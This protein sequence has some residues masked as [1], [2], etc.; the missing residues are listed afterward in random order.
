MVAAG[1]AQGVTADP[2]GGGPSGELAE[3]DGHGDGQGSG[4]THRISIRYGECDQQGVV[5][6][7]HYLAF[8]DD[9]MDHWMRALGGEEWT[10]GW[11]VMLKSAAVT[12]EG[13]ARW[14]EVLEID[15]EVRRWGRTSFDVGF[16]MRV[17]AR[18]VADAVVTYVS[19]D[20]TTQ[21]PV[22]PPA[23]V[24]DAMGPARSDRP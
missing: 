15:C 6:N 8:V 4:H 13:P 22:E 20:P 5:F 3:R 7:A 16:A 17:G 12:W 2:S 11:D 18:A 14:P 21:R 19:I 24:V 9:A 23:R 10:S 1:G